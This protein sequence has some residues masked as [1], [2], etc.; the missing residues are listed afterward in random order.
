MIATR[1]RTT[2]CLRLI[3]HRVRSRHQPTRPWVSTYSSDGA[4]ASQSSELW[5]AGK[6]DGSSPE[7]P[8]PTY[9]NLPGFRCRRHKPE[10]TYCVR[11]AD[12]VVMSA[13]A[14]GPHLSRR[15]A[16]LRNSRRGEADT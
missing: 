14:V 2:C 16:K 8:W 7:A 5:S 13:A 9:S 12:A 1:E 11:V 6:D 4:D 3:I 15:L 10:A